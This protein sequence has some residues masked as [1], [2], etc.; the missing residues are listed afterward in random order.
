MFS[1]KIAEKAMSSLVGIIGGKYT[2]FTDGTV[3][4]T[5]RKLDECG[6][7]KAVVLSIATKPS[8]QTVINDWAVTLQ[9]EYP[10]RLFVF[11]TVH[12]EADDVLQ[13]LD[14]IKSLGLYGIK[15]HPE[16]QKF[17]INDEKLYRIYKRCGELKLPVIF[18][19]GYDPVEPY[20]RRAMPYHLKD[21]AEK[22]PETLFI[23]GHYGGMSSWEDVLHYAAGLP[24]VYLDTSFTAEFL[25]QEL[26]LEILNKH[27]ADKILFASDC[28]WR[29]IRDESEYIEQMPLPDE[30]K[31]LIFYKNAERILQL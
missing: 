19:M 8:Q 27:G 3:K 7:D 4:D 12:P 18:H 23:G 26:F 1:D 21:I 13:E 31:E 15:L 14:R 6:I 25:P 5:L 11:G 17:F 29:N 22:F 10:E 28:P 9:K 30:I 20:K 2:P 24:N 16:Y